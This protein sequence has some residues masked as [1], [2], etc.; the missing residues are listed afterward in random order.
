MRRPSKANVR[1]DPVKLGALDLAHRRFG[2]RSAADLG[3]VWAVD[4]GY[5]LHLA[6]KPG[7]ER[8]VCVDENF[9]AAASSAIARRRNV[10][11]VPGN[12]ADERVREAVGRVDAIIMF[13]VL[14]H[15][16]APDWDEVIARYATQAS[17]LILAGPW[18]RAGRGE[19]IRLLELGEARYLETVCEQKL[20]VGLFDR[21]DEVNDQRGRPW[22][23]VHDIWQWGITDAD[24]RDHVA[25]LG[26]ELAFY[27]NHGAW[28]SLPAFTDGVYVFTRPEL[29]HR[30]P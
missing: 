26:F 19:T 29:L 12:F 16:V 14:L 3:A 15:Q 23:D 2:L 5:S 1:L 17:C 30:Q 4:A 22:R 6:A 7:I 24:L 28:R 13:D 8:V 21:L 10:S 25:G 18:Y 20:N 11:E 9:T 27:E